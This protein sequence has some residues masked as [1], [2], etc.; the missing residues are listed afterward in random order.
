MEVIN[1][2]TIER[3]GRGFWAVA[4][5]IR[6]GPYPRKSEAQAAAMNTLAPPPPKPLK[7]V[8]RD[9]PNADGE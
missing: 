2:W 1:G 6:S 7:I 9:E 4:G 3:D 5:T 8:R